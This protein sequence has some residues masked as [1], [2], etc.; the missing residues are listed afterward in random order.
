MRGLY[1]RNG[2]YWARFKVRGIEYRES[3]RTRS[4]A[5][6]ERLLTLMKERVQ[7]AAYFGATD[8]VGWQAAV[9]SWASAWRQ[10]NISASTGAR[11]LTSLGQVRRWLDPVT[12]QKIDIPL[13]KEIVRARSRGGAS[14]ATIRRDMTAISSV[15]GHCV[16]ENWIEENPAHMMDRSRFKE[17]AV[18]IIL[19]KEEHL[20]RVLSLDSRFMDIARLSLE[21]GMRQEECAGLE[22][23]RIDRRRM[24]A[25]LEDTKSGEVREVPLS[26]KALAIIDRQ[27]PF[28]RCPFVF[29]RGDGERF[30]N[31]DAQFYA[32]VKRVARNAAQAGEPFKRFRFHDLRHLFAVTFLR[33]RRGSIY[34]LQER[35]GHESVTTTE[36]YLK[37]LTPEEAMLAKHGVARNPA[38]DQRFADEKGGKNG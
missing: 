33:E 14:N 13:L 37:S 34:E 28:L 20:A 36:R 27:P 7:D 23:D 16:D 15:L 8:P 4:E 11:Y 9:V 32:T 25:T 24:S 22:H 10:L 35:L 21:T 19:P 29:W 12:V 3:L 30:Q 2:I 31:V 1:Q 26:A 6:A 17:K 38:Q 5:R 18:K